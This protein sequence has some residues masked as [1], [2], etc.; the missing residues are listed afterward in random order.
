VLPSGTHTIR[1]GACTKSI[2]DERATN[3]EELDMGDHWGGHGHDW[4]GWGDD[5]DDKDW[6]G[7]GKDDCDDDGWGKWGDCKD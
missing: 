3:G 6:G 4:G 5:G 2:E 7:W 1:C